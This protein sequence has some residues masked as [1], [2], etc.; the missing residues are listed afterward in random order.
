MS[1]ILPRAEVRAMIAKGMS[2]AA[3]IFPGFECGVTSPYPIVV[4]VVIE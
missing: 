2:I 1:W 4:S 3:M